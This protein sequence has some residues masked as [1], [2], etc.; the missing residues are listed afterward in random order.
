VR[1]AR[2]DKAV[3]TKSK[4]EIFLQMGLDDP[5]QLEMARQIEFYVQA[6]PA[7]FSGGPIKS[8]LL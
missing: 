3:S 2:I 1:D 5:N 4:S 8:R 6:I 7:A